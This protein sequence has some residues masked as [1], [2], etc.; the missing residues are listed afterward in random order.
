M[1][2]NIKTT[3]NLEEIA[4]FV[5]NSINKQL[6]EGKRVLWFVTG[7]SS[8]KVQSKVADKINTKLPGRLVITLTDERYGEEN[9]PDS[10][11]YQLKQLGFE[12]EKT[13]IITFL[14]G[15]SFTDT[16]KRLREVLKEELDKADYKIGNFGI[17]IDGHTAG[18]LPHTAA[19]DSPDLVCAYE[20]PLFN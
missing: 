9:H 5:A 15:E 16:T 3:N 7:G 1:S 20:T 8:I 19:V 12:I 4:D 11:W 13:K 6:A 14:T 18:I 10:N 2:L 17:G